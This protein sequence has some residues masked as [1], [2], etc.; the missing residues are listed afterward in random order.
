LEHPQLSGATP[1]TLG[2]A[3]CCAADNSVIQQTIIEGL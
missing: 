1:G 2:A 3:L